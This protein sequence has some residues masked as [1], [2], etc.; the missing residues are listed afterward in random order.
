MSAQLQLDGQKLLPSVD[1]ARC[2][3]AVRRVLDA[4]PIGELG[5]GIT[6]VDDDAIATL[7]RQ[8]RGMDKPTDVLSFAAHDGELIAGLE[9]ELGDLVI[10]VPTATR[11]ARAL[12][13]PLA[14]ELAVLTTHGLLHLCGFDHEHD[15]ADA[16]TMAELE[17]SILD[18]AGVPIEAALIGRTL[19]ASRV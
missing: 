1:R 8:W 19:H 17:L 10:A 13:H 4:A 6:F 9:E 11:Q 7:N 2:L 16:K 18:A 14:T 5:L 12:G 3:R 15:P